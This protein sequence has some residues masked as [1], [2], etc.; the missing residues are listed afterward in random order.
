MPNRLSDGLGR[1]RAAHGA[2]SMIVLSVTRLSPVLTE[3]CSLFQRS[4]ASCSRLVILQEPSLGPLCSYILV[5]HLAAN[6]KVHSN[7][8]LLRPR[9]QHDA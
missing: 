7:R 1:L 2:A 3:T 8:S 5:R 9:R 6:I 4:R